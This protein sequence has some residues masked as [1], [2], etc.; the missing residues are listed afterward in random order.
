MVKRDFRADVPLVVHWDEKL[1]EELTNKEHVDRLPIL[2]LG[3][4]MEELT[5]VPKLPA[6]GMEENQVP[7]II[8][9]L[10]E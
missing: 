3:E 5:G 6:G 2:V 4:G 1:M 10:E 9:A 7:A 8:T